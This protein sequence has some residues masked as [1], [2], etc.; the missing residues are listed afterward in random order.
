M[1]L[2]T[3]LNDLV[4]NRSLGSQ[5]FCGHDN[6]LN[7]QKILDGSLQLHRPLSRVTATRK[8]L[9]YPQLYKQHSNWVIQF[10]IGSKMK[11]LRV[12]L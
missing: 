11:T 10:T 3:A 5:P 2:E 6:P 12:R 8:Y 1:A 7:T 4:P 9:M